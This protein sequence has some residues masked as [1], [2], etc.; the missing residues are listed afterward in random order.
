MGQ[1][2]RGGTKCD[3]KRDLL[4][5]RSPLEEMKYLYKFTCPILCS[6]VEVKRGIE[7]R[8]STQCLDNSGATGVSYH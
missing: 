2:W 1:S 4:G 7:S 3:C 6:S 8:H 5:V